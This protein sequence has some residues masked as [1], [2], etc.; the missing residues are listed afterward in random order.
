MYMYICCHCIEITTVNR[1]FTL[2]ECHD[3]M[4]SY[5]LFNVTL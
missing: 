4:T 3:S 5:G 1:K 2:A